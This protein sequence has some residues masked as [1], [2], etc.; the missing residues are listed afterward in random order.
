[1]E[2]NRNNYEEFFLLYVDNEL[3]AA[4]RRG[5]EEFVQTNPDLKEELYLLTETILVS[6]NNIVF[7]N[8]EEL[9]KQEQHKVIAIAWWRIAA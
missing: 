7:E 1:M 9:Y 5:V 6:D 2:I 4:Q 8:K 3:P